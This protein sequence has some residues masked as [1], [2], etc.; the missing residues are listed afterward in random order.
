MVIWVVMSVQFRK[1][2][3]SGNLSPL[4]SGSKNKPSKKPAETV[5]KVSLLYSSV[6]KMEV[7]ASP[8]C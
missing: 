5:D 6:L 1:T 7:I 2:N 4:F 3:I 8:K